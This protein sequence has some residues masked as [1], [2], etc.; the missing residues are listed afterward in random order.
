MSDKPGTCSICLGDLINSVD[1]AVSVFSC[2]HMIHAGCAANLA[3]SMD[4]PTC[5]LCRDSS[6]SSNLSQDL[7]MLAEMGPVGDDPASTTTTPSLTQSGPP[8]DII[9]L[10]HNRLGPPPAFSKLPDRRVQYCGRAHEEYECQTCHRTA[11]QAV[12]QSLETVGF[13]DFHG[14]LAKMIDLET[15]ALAEVCCR[16]TSGYDQPELEERCSAPFVVRM[17][18]GVS[19]NGGT[20]LDDGEDDFNTLPVALPDVVPDDMDIQPGFPRA[21]PGIPNAASSSGGVIVIDSQDSV[22]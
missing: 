9:V 15:G 10:C 12:L 16:F 21:S 20:Q 3:N 19:S 7:A 17:Y 18:E 1:T 22:L 6:W 2:A 14:R 13:C 8:H 4:D 5:P 11:D